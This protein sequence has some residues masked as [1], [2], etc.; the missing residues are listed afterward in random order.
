MKEFCPA[1]RARGASGSPWCRSASLGACVPALELLLLAIAMAFT[2]VRR[3]QRSSGRACCGPSGCALVCSRCCPQL[4][5]HTTHVES[6]PKCPPLSDPRQ[7][8]GSR[9]MHKFVPCWLQLQ[10]RL[11]TAMVGWQSSAGRDATSAIRRGGKPVGA[12]QV[13]YS[14]TVTAT[15]TYSVQLLPRSLLPV[16]QLYE[17]LS[18]EDVSKYSLLQCLIDCAMSTWAWY[19]YLTFNQV[20]TPLR[21]NISIPTCLHMQII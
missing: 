4:Y 11:M 21:L 14:C 1:V 19:E 16:S 17:C 2:A 20:W 9:G 18:P 3:S 13:L 15:S 7:L 6:L 10:V 12:I 8:F 5:S